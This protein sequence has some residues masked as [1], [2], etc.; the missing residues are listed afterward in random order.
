MIA[1]QVHCVEKTREARHGGK[2]ISSANLMRNQCL[3][4]KIYKIIEQ[5]FVE[6]CRG[7]KEEHHVVESDL[8]GVNFLFLIERYIMKFSGEMFPYEHIH[9]AEMCF[10]HP[11]NAL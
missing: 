5:K 9:I 2:P 4:N 7:G 1:A 6:E 11:K 10:T 8:I 3:R